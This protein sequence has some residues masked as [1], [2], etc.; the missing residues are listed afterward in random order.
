MSANFTLKGTDNLIKIF[1]EYPERGYRKPVMAGF[2][3][4][5]EPV[6]KAMISA[7]PSVID[8]TKK[9]IK[10]KAAKG[11]ALFLAVG[12][13]SKQGLYRN[14]R[15]QMWDPYQLLY[16]FNYGT[17]SNRFSGHNFVKARKTGSAKWR[18]GIMPGLFMENA[19]EQTQGEA[20]KIF[21]DTADR[22]AIKFMESEAAK[23][24]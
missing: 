18:G 14:R 5:A 4:A 3:K 16:W 9:A 20:Q 22:E 11:G 1:R 10:I 6:R 12:A 24:L 15:G 8:P 17:L 2:R 23:L 13:F 19:W 21:E 7:V